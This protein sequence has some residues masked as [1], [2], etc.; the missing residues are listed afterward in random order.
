M[1]TY[2]CYAFYNPTA[3]ITQAVIAHEASHCAYFI[4]DIEYRGQ[5]VELV[6]I[7]TNKIFE[8]KDTQLSIY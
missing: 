8:E 6:F 4:S 2:K 7:I 1:I 3:T 5:L